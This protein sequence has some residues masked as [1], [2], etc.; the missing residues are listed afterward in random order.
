MKARPRA[1]R[2]GLLLWIG[3]TLYGLRHTASDRS[4][5]DRAFRL[6]KRDGTT[7]DVIR[8]RYGPECDCPDF[9]YRR[10]G[11]DPLGCKHIRALRACGLLAGDGAN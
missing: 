3:E 6:A 2:V 10:D 11:L 1:A 8:T 7:Y 4:I 9:L 5:G